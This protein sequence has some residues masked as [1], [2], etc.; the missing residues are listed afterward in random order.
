MVCN[1]LIWH[2]SVISTALLSFRP[3]GEISR[4]RCR[5]IGWFQKPTVQGSKSKLSPSSASF[6]AVGEAYRA[7]SHSFDMTV[8]FL[9]LAKNLLRID[10]NYKIFL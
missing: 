4:P 7:C 10:G 6:I 9:A 5:E 2:F 8:L 1:R 3:E